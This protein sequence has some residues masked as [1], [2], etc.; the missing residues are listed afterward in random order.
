LAS[1]SSIYR[2]VASSSARLVA[3]SSVG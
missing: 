1:A 3:S 2:K